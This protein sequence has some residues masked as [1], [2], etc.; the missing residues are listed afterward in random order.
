[1]ASELRVHTIR[2]DGHRGHVL[3]VLRGGDVP[4]LSSEDE[5]ARG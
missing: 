1:M 5:A 3:G 4:V 2:T